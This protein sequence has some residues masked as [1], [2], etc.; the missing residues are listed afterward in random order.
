[1]SVKRLVERAIRHWVALVNGAVAVFL[2]LPFM[3]PVLL[4]TGHAGLAN[5][6]YDAYQVTCHE[7]A[8]RSYFLFGPQATYS[9]S[10]LQAHGVTSPATFRGAPDLGFKVAFCQRNVAIY[11]AALLAGLVY[12]WRRSLPPLGFGGY[13]VLMLPMALDGFTQLFG[14]RESTWELRTVTGALFGAG[15]VWLLYPR[16]DRLLGPRAKAT[17]VLAVREC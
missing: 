11:G 16:I 17:P 10:D 5:A 14:W 13:V 8:S 9:F 15:S 2:A 7:W 1:M 12:A 4:Y 6:I 3:A